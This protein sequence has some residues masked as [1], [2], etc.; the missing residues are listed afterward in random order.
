MGELQ[1]DLRVTSR[2]SWWLQ[3]V[4]PNRGCCGAGCRS[5]GQYEN[6][7][8][9]RETAG[10]EEEEKEEEE[11]RRGGG[12]GR[13]RRGTQCGRQAHRNL[14]SLLSQHGGSRLQLKEAETAGFAVS[15]SL[16]IRVSSKPARAI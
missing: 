3:N 6:K 5:R 8:Q 9:R 7:R 10:G 14:A 12:G 1:G 16:G 13:G 4:M 11:E 2:E 15:L